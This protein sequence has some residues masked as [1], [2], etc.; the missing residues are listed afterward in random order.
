MQGSKKGREVR[1]EQRLVE[2]SCEDGFAGK[3][4]PP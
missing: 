4:K 3:E 2:V 1:S